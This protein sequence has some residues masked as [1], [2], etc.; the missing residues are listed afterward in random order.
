MRFLSA[1]HKMRTL[2]AP[3]RPANRSGPPAVPGRRCQSPDQ[4]NHESPLQTWEISPLS[5]H[6]ERQMGNYTHVHLARDICPWRDLVANK[7]AEAK[8][9]TAMEAD[10]KRGNRERSE[11]ICPTASLRVGLVRSPGRP[12]A[13]VIGGHTL[14]SMRRSL[15][16][17]RLAD[18]VYPVH[19]P[20]P[21]Q[22]RLPCAALSA[23]FVLSRTSGLAPANEAESF[24]LRKP[25]C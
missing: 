18:S 14:A 11:A 22:P 25:R 4:P 5:A 2:H 1:Q 6:A 13:H 23:R 15:T 10:A 16:L 17:A 3:G 7:E 9:G 12:P 21:E 8:R 24:V 19:L 20:S